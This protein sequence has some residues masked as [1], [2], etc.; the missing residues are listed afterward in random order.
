MMINQTQEASKLISSAQLIC[1]TSGEPAGI[2][3][4]ICLDLAFCTY[5]QSH[6]LVVIGDANLLH[7]RAQQIGKDVV[8][9]AVNSTA[10]ASLAPAK[11]GTLRV[12]HLP[13]PQA[14]CLGKPNI[15]NAPYVLQILDQAISLCQA[16]LSNI[17][18]TAPL[19]KA[20][21]N[22]SGISFT[23][24][25]EYLAAKFAVPKVIM[26]LSNPQLNVALLTTHLPLR[27]VA[28]QITRENLNQALNIIQQS[29]N[30]NFAIHKPR[31][32]VCGLNPHA[33]EEGYL[34]DEEIKII[35]PVI[36]HWQ[37]SGYPVFGAFPADTIYN[38]AQQYDV[39]LAM[40][41]DQGLPVVKYTDFEHGVNTTLGLPIIRTSVDHGTALN[42][43]GTGKA[44][45]VSL[46]SALEFALKK[47]SK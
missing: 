42:L 23:G 28:A 2:G 4:E 31:I 12:L 33:G 20:L 44:S 11:N 25:T 18:V 17:I 24:H 35:N 21:I 38:Q 14:D 32:G 16:K 15:A 34:G 10:L 3:P 22:Q 26:M 7:H 30:L 40:Y 1:I 36:Q 43:A 45:S 37:N 29:F 19:N 13:C 5:N 6:K 41:H 9:E 39:I 47:Y 8:I 46:I 27:Q